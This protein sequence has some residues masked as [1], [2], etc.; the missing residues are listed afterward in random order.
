MVKAAKTKKHPGGRPKIDPAD[1][2]TERLAVRLH[3]D[4]TTEVNRACRLMGMN[5]SIFFERL[6]IDW[7]NARAEVMRIRPLDLIGRYMTDEDLA[8]EG[9]P[10]PRLHEPSAITTRLPGTAYPGSNNVMSSRP[11]HADRRR[12]RAWSTRRTRRS[13][14]GND[15]KLGS[16]RVPSL[17]CRRPSCPA[18]HSE[19]GSSPEIMRRVRTHLG[20]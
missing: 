12:C 15:P 14:S 17:N 1:L 19:F 7:V 9:A 13:R 20:L 18:G 5:R 16:S 4:L 3:P 11:P 10:G 2:R 8:A 6:L